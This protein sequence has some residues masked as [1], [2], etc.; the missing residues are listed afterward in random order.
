LL[1][2]FLFN[3]VGPLSQFLSVSTA[4]KYLFR[5]KTSCLS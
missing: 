3:D 5:F 2:H 4:F 1:P